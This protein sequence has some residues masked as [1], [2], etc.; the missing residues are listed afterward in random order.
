MEHITCYP[1]IALANFKWFLKEA[2]DKKS[3]KHLEATLIQIK[4]VCTDVEVN[5]LIEAYPNKLLIEK[6]LFD[7]GRYTFTIN[8]KL[9]HAL[10]E[11]AKQ[12]LL[13]N[14]EIERWEIV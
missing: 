7:D 13:M 8:S 4:A 11:E 9:F 14:E 5:Q 12:I 10:V 1:I 2:S 6:D 3:I